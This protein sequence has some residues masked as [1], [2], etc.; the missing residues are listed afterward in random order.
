MKKPYDPLSKEVSDR[1]SEYY[2]KGSISQDLR[3]GNVAFQGITITG[4]G[5]QGPSSST[6]SFQSLIGKTQHNIG[7]IVSSG[8]DDYSLGLRLNDELVN[9]SNFSLNYFNSIT[10]DSVKNNFRQFSIQSFRV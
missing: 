10:T 4:V 8:K 7:E 2:K 1:Y 9:G 5:I 6:L 3:F